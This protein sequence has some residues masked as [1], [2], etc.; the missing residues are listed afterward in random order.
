MKRI[1]ADHIGFNEIGGAGE[2]VYRVVRFRNYSP[3]VDEQ[4][5]Q[6][7][8]PVIF[9][10]MEP[11]EGFDYELNGA[12]L[13]YSLINLYHE[14]NDP[15]SIVPIPY[16]ICVWCRDHVQPY[17]LKML[18]AMMEGY[19]KDSWPEW[20]LL[21]KEASFWVD[22]FTHDLCC[23][24]ATMDF[25][26][27]LISVRIRKDTQ[28]ARSLY[29]EGRIEDGLPFFERYRHI[30]NNAEYIQTVMND[31][32]SLTD[33]LLGLFPEHRM[34]LTKNRINGTIGMYGDIDSVFDLAWYAFAREVATDAPPPDTDPDSLALYGSS[35]YICCLSCGRYVKRKGPRQRYCDDPDCQ[36][37]RKRINSKDCYDR[38]KMKRDDNA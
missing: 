38:K 32:D 16:R 29:Y 17:S 2:I 22:S 24:G 20:P 33:S 11:V 7:V 10:G 37:V 30:E 35:S 9:P 19:G 26:K 34:K 36:A 4:G 25:Y 12:E 21:Q 23:L 15:E 18:S 8:Q 31:Y 6:I 3:D 27:A 13:L 14:L 28:K 1:G 5:K